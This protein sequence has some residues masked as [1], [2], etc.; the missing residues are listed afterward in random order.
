[1]ISIQLDDK[2]ERKYMT[3]SEILEKYLNL[4][5]SCLTESEKVQLR[6]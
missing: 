5:N 4:D 1:M 6:T 2:Y 3:D